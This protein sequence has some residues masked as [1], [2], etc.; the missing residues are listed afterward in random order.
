MSE[1]NKDIQD[2]KKEPR[3]DRA[4]FDELMQCSEDEKK[5]ITQTP[6]GHRRKEWQYRLLKVCATDDEGLKEWNEWRNEDLGEEILLEGADLT[7]AYLKGAHL[8]FAKLKGAILWKAHLKGALLIE[9][10]LEGAN[11][12]EASLQG[13]HLTDAHLKGAHLLEAHLENARLVW[14]DLKGADFSRSIVDGGTLIWNCTVDRKTK[15]EGVGLD[16][17]RIYPALKQLLEYNIRR[18]NWQDWYRGE[19]KK[20]W[21][22][23]IWYK[24]KLKKEW[25]ITTRQVITSPVRLFWWTSNYGLSTLRIILAF[26]ILAFA[27]AGV[28]WLC[29]NCIMVNGNVGD[30]RGLL[31]AI[32]FSVVTMTTLGFGD[33]AANPDSGWGQ[34]L[35]MVQVLLGYVL[36]AALVTRFAVLFTAGGPAGSFSKRPKKQTKKPLRQK[37]F[38]DRTFSEWFFGE[39][40]KKPTKKPKEDKK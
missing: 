30:L 34:V 37:L 36:L 18:M 15:F 10:H 31:H 14:S 29:P 3:F 22:I 40:P 21:I 19:P 24:G 20:K 6:K 39:Q 25:I 33:I 28:Y 9:A 35:L 4:K 12:D 16:S 5:R 38:G 23:T 32:Y 17:A 13:A 11:L 8:V 1:E 7:E 27:F 2:K 26:F